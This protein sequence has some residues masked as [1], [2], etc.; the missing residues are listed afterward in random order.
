MLEDVSRGPAK[1]KAHKHPTVIVTYT[2]G[3]AEGS[4]TV[5]AERVFCSDLIAARVL[6]VSLKFSLKN[7]RK[8]DI[9]LERKKCSFSLDKSSSEVFKEDHVHV[10]LCYNLYLGCSREGII[11]FTLTL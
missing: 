9:K 7:N 3:D 11:G 6:V 4:V 2:T 1:T 8:K 5:N 10:I